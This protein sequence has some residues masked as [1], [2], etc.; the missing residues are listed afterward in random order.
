MSE[1]FRLGPDVIQHIASFCETTIPL[2]LTSK[3]LFLILHGEKSSQTAIQL[4]KTHP[5]VFFNC[6]P[7]TTPLQVA[8]MLRFGL[9]QLLI[10]LK[11]EISIR[12]NSERFFGEE[13]FKN[14]RWDPED[15]ITFSFAMERESTQ[16]SMNFTTLCVF[17]RYCPVR[18]WSPSDEQLAEELDQQTFQFW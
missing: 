8:R 5:E 1:L 4:L 14:L 18:D 3:E 15:Q 9:G 11:D 12:T 17:L 6:F 2:A 10:T 7:T 16:K 13:C